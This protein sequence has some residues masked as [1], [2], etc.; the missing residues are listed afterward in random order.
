MATT[1]TFKKPSVIPGFGLL[2]EDITQPYLH[3]YQLTGG[4][5]IFRDDIRI[6]Y[7]P[8]CGVRLKKLDG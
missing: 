2:S 5:C 8:F 7:E 1:F 4:E 6:P 3:H